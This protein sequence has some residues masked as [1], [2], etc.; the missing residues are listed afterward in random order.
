MK[1]TENI[2]KLIS[3]ILMVTPL[4]IFPFSINGDY[5][6]LPKLIF[7]GIL[8]L[9]MV[10]IH[11]LSPERKKIKLDLIT[12]LIILYFIF[13]IISTIFSVDP[14][15]SVFG[16]RKR[17]EG[18]IT[19]F[20]YL[21][22]FLFTKTYYK[23]D[24]KH[25]YGFFIT[26]IL[27]CIYGF[28]QFFGLD[29]IP[30]DIIRN[31]PIWNDR[32]FSTIGNPNFL[33]SYL[34]L[35]LPVSM[36]IYLKNNKKYILFINVL[37]FSI[38]IITRTR[39]AWLAFIFILFMFLIYV[40]KNPKFFR[41]FVVLISVFTISFVILNIN[42]DQEYLSRFKSIK[43]DVN[44]I[45][46]KTI[47]QKEKDLSYLRAGS[48]RI[49]VWE[50]S[51]ELILERPLFGYGLEKLKK[52][53]IEKY[54]FEMIDTFGGI[55]PFDRAH[56]EYLH[57][58]VSTG[59]PSLFCYLLFLFLSLKKGFQRLKKEKYYFPILV[60]ICAY[61]IQAFFNISVVSVA[62]IYWIF[63]GLLVNE[64]I[65]EKDENK[66]VSKHLEKQ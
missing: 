49:Y 21:G 17:E 41:S 23:F 42:K 24:K 44:L 22:L 29:F 28:L 58:A 51:F 10:L 46:E 62:Y 6:Y 1:K 63:L 45:K 4:I 8:F 47:N 53:I 31:A 20:L 36:Y 54:Y 56:N 13:V 48:S 15:E 66:I 3:L 38:L 50:K 30:R 16:A 7:V 11:I 34:I 12:K 32:I 33:G 57:I 5:F 19:I 35:S 43:E 39:S 27:V 37:L 25:L 14:M 40:K 64:K 61:L 65:L 60:A 9:F 52:V 2:S 26:S 59:L 18:L 55:Q